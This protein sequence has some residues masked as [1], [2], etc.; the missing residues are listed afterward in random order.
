[1]RWTINWGV[2][3]ASGP[4]YIAGCGDT[5]SKTSFCAPSNPW[6]CGCAKNTLYA[7]HIVYAP[8]GLCNCNCPA[9]SISVIIDG[10]ELHNND[11]FCCPNVMGGNCG[12]SCGCARTEIDCNNKVIEMKC[13]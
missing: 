6:D 10:T 13:P 12:N 8:P 4:L 3:C 5:T 1:M 9:D 2:D 11:V 7:S